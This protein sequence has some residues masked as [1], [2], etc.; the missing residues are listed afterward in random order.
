MQFPTISIVMPSLNSEKYIGEAIESVINQNYPSLEFI[1]ID[2]GSTDNTINII[3]SYEKH[4]TYWISEKDNGHGHALNKGFARSTGEIMAWLNSDD[5]YAPN[6]FFTVAKVFSQF[7]DVNWLVGK[8]SWWNKAGQQT[9]Q[10]HVYKNIYDFLLGNYRWIQQESVFWRRTLWEKT[11]SHINE[12]YAFM[13]DGELW[14]RFFLEDDLWH[15][16]AVLSGYRVHDTNRA[17]L[18]MDCVIAEMERAIKELRNKVVHDAVILN[19][20]EKIKN[21]PQYTDEAIDY[22]IITQMAKGLE[23]GIIKYTPLYSPKPF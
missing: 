2:G 3:R 9:A 5:K 20:L 16:D 1:V 14:T 13:V 11:G 22:K 17:A 8:N 10:K 4:L 12:D 6:A 18:F 19:N 15:I 23:K 7:P 21:L